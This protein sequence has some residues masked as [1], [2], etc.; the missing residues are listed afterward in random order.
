MKLPRDLKWVTIG[1]QYNHDRNTEV[2]KFKM[3]FFI[4]IQIS[5][6]CYASHSLPSSLA[7]NDGVILVVKDALDGHCKLGG[8][9]GGGGGVGG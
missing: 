8:G 7:N 2:N 4:S 5:D 3:Q 9:L 6:S 1:L